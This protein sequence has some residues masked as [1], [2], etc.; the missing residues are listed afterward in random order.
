MSERS[1]WTPNPGPQKRAYLSPFRETLYGGGR[2][3]GKSAGLYGKVIGRVGKYGKKCNMAFFRSN[4]NDLE[5]LIMKGHEFLCA[6][7]L[8]DF[9][10]GQQRMFR[11]KGA[12]AGSVLKMRTIEHEKDLLKFKGHE[13][14][15]MGFDE[16]TDF[17]VPFD[18]IRDKMGASLRNKHGIPGQILYTG[19]PGGFNHGAVVDYFKIDQHPKGNIRFRNKHGLERIFIPSTYRD[20][21]ILT[22][23][24]PDYVLALQ[25]IKDPDLRKAWLDGAWNVAMGSMFS[26]VYN[27]NIHVADSIMPSDIPTHIKRHRALDWGSSSPFAVLWYFISDGTKLKSG[28]WFPRGA[29]V[30]YRE[31]YGWKKGMSINEGLRLSSQQVCEEIRRIEAR[32]GDSRFVEA[33]PA[34]TQIF[35]V[36]DGTPIYKSFRDKEIYFTECKKKPGSIAIMCQLMRDRLVG[37]EYPMIYFTRDC[38]NLNRTLPILVRSLRNPEKIEDGQEDHLSDVV[39]YVCM[40]HVHDQKTE[41]EINSSSKKQPDYLRKLI[42]HRR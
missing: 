6:Q 5:D 25:S 28:A 12:F 32:S 27:K 7:G 11:F 16:I 41:Y 31:Y 26:D 18:T 37:E 3:S 34:D 22:D 4:S 30:F 36:D 24:D 29:I 23:A 2:G 13:Y 17:N 10:G 19:N 39:G 38:V 20:N 14:D 15:L 1:Y 33:G 42:A 9:I 35:R 21:P 40:D 8:A